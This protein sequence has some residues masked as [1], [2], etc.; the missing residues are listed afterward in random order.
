MSQDIAIKFV[1]IKVNSFDWYVPH[2]TLSFPQQAILPKETLS[3]V[4]TELQY[5]ERSVS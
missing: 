5:L 1:K 3:K 4:P 2:Y